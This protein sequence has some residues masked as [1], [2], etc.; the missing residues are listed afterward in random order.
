LILAYR[1]WTSQTVQRLLARPRID[2]GTRTLSGVSRMK[3]KMRKHYFD[4]G[5]FDSDNL[6]PQNQEMPYEVIWS[7]DSSLIG[8]KR[9]VQR[10]FVPTVK[11]VYTYAT[12]KSANETPASRTHRVGGHESPKQAQRV[13]S[14]N[15]AVSTSSGQDIKFDGSICSLKISNTVDTIQTQS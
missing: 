15:Q 11:P 1:L 6:C 9:G 5:H 14:G 7:T 3:L 12:R 10:D 13:S 2:L 8:R 4:I